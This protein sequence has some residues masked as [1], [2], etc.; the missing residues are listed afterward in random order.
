MRRVDSRRRWPHDDA[1]GVAAALDLLRFFERRRPGRVGVGIGHRQ[2]HAH[3]RNA[4]ADTMVQAADQCAAVAIAFDEVILPER[5]RKV[6]R[7]RHQ[8]ADQRLE[9]GG[10]ARS[11]Q[12]DAM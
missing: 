8:V 2:E 3:Q 6:Q 12:S 11:R 5:L 10:I 7:R 1:Q 4:I 9:G